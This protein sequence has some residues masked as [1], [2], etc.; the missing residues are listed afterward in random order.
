MKNKYRSSLLNIIQG[1][2]VHA[3]NRSLGS[4]LGDYKLISN[5]DYPGE[6]LTASAELRKALKTHNVDMDEYVRVSKEIGG[7]AI[8]GF[9]AAIL[10]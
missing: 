2:K 3:L 9:E 4:A 1:D 8:L 7:P 5:K 10:V 6:F